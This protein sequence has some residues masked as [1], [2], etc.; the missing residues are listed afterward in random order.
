MNPKDAVAT[1]I[2]AR[3]DELFAI[4]AEARLQGMDVAGRHALRQQQAR[5]LL[6]EIQEQIEAARSIG[7][8]CQCARQGLPVHAHPVAE[9]HALPAISRTGA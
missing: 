5:P 1:G 3:M 6:E 8:T 7:V 4:D 2:V 9:T